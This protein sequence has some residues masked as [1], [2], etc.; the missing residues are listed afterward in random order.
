MGDWQETLTAILV[1]A[2]PGTHWE[3]GWWFDYNWDTWENKILQLSESSQKHFAQRTKA[4]KLIKVSI[5]HCKPLRQS[6]QMRLMK[7][8]PYL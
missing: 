4:K 8:L 3:V 1:C 7:V 5:I 6:R 2:N